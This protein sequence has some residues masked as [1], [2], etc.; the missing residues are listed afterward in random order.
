MKPVPR[1]V[2]EIRADWGPPY[3]SLYG[4]ADHLWT[5]YWDWLA[6]EV[7]DMYKLRGFYNIDRR[8]M[9]ISPNNTHITDIIEVDAMVYRG[10]PIVHLK[11]VDRVIEFCELTP[12]EIVLL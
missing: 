1:I 2:R 3:P 9:P 11:D 8:C 12:E 4:F 10:V 5:E 6:P 7:K